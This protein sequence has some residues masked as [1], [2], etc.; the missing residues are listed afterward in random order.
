[1]APVTGRILTRQHLDEVRALGREPLDV[2]AANL[3]LE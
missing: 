1:M 3:D 2:L